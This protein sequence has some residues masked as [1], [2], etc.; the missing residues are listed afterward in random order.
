[1][2]RLCF[3]LVAMFCMACGLS[4]QVMKLEHYPHIPLAYDGVFVDHVKG[5]VAKVM[6]SAYGQYFGQI[7]ITGDIYGYG[8]FYTEQDGEVIGQFRNGNCFFGIR[9]GSQTVKVGAEEHYIVYDLRTGDPLYVMIGDDKL[10][11]TEDYKKKY[12]FQSLTYA[13]GDRYVGETVNGKREGYGLYYY[14]NGNY[15]YGRYKDNA[16][17]GFGAMFKTD[18]RILIIDWEAK[19]SEE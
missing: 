7:T 11:L 9:L 8:A 15:C 12:R 2:R 3:L 19:D 10:L 16:Q 4:A 18:S 14:T 6:P 13:N 17:Y 5:N 1:M